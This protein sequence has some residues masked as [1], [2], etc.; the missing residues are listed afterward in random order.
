MFA[1]ALDTLEEPQI[2]SLIEDVKNLESNKTNFG[3]R[4]LRLINVENPARL[5]LEIEKSIA[6]SDNQ[7]SIYLLDQNNSII[8]GHSSVILKFQN[9]RRIISA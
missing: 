2:I 5:K 6:N 4:K 7:G 9:Q 3:F 8:T 1:F